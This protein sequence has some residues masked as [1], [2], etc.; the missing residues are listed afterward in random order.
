MTYKVVGVKYN[1]YEDWRGGKTNNTPKM[2]IR[3]VSANSIK[4]TIVELLFG[5]DRY[6]YVLINYGGKLFHAERDGSNSYIR[7]ELTYHPLRKH[8]ME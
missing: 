7:K 3:H 8:V 4:D 1:R 6:S 2:S 5:S